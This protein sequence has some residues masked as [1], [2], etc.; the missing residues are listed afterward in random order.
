MN[1]L[2]S[3]LLVSRT[4]WSVAAIGMLTVVS[5]A[6]RADTI[7]LWLF[8]E[9]AG[10]Y[11]SCVLGD[12]SPNNY[13]LVLGRGG[14]IV[15]GNFGHALEPIEQLKIELSTANRFTGFERRPKLDA[16]RKMPPMDWSNANFCALMTRGEQHLRQEVGFASATKTRLNLGDFDWTVEFWYRPSR[17]TDEDGVVLEIGAGPRGENDRVTQLLLNADGHGLTLWNE[18]GG[19]RLRIPSD[20]AAIAP[21]SAQWCHLAFV[22][23]AAGRQPR[24]Y[25]D[26]KL[27]SLPKTCAL[28]PL[29]T[30]D[31]DY[32]SIG[33]DAQWN[34]P[35]PGRLDELRIS[36]AQVYTRDFTPPPTFS[37]YD[38]AT[39]K[40][41]QLKAGPP[42]LFAGRPAGDEVIPLGLRKYVFID[43][44][45]IADSE[46]ISFNVNPPRPAER[47]LNGINGHLVVFDDENDLIRLYYKEQG[48]RL[49]VLTSRDGV[50]FDKPDLGRRS[51]TDSNIVIDQP[52]GLGTI[53][54]DPNAPAD[55]RIKY[56]SGYQGRGI[57]IYSSPDGYNFTRN[58]TSALPF[59]GA[60][61][62]IA[63]Y[64][65]Q[66]QKYVAF[67][68]TDMPETV[69]GHTERAFVRTE[70]TDPMRPW[71][72]APLSQ[73]EQ[74]EIGKHR[75]IGSKLPW[76]LDNGPLSPPG[77]GVEYPTAFATDEAL[78][79]MGTDIYVPKNV[80]YEWA[81][82][83]YLAFPLMYLHYHDE[84]PPTRQ[85]LGRR[86]RDRGSGPLETQIAVSRDGVHWKRYPR[87]AY[88]K[89]GRH[90]GLDIHKN[91]IAHGMVGRGE[92]IWQYYLG[93]EDYHSTWSGGGREAVF[94]VVQRLDGFISADA[95][96]T[97][98][99]IVTRPFVFEGNRLALN[100]DTGAIGFAQVGLL[101][102]GGK[103]I[104][105]F[106]VDDCVYINGD[107]IDTEVEWLGKGSDVSAL[108]GRPVQL[109][110]QM[111]GTK[112]YS[113][114]FVAR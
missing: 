14:Q 108:A 41:P 6:T 46:N 60:S 98:G 74:R 32:I 70:T 104:P 30:G 55:E 79:P 63:Y 48:D 16:S 88:I 80:K 33:R 45:I 12:A 73:A 99:T 71:P 1:S 52:V 97:G 110:F 43:D 47:V 38:H 21:K 61:Q 106:G 94:R 13:P 5:V 18:P 65:D 107:F 114:Q 59:R 66:Q 84:G 10:L 8:D 67:H 78:D 4:T 9:Q 31:E 44:A 85:V 86:D 100:I 51:E 58:E 19:V 15:E 17:K 26:G 72:L 92:E 27:Q 105:G 49:A 20:V 23:D 2:C 69:N 36:D 111:R 64:D 54:V 7:A 102:Q 83:P 50:H 22:Y 62:S 89:I 87:P 113:M 3:P 39:Y 95:A 101:D 68:R 112:L 34:R 90:D 24:H 56:M 11:P 91:Y 96:Y 35:L 75:R 53:L 81:T 76:Y 40:P 109:V 37:K 42:L 82:E 25:V 77:F 93:S 29:P 28:K 57:Y 103:P